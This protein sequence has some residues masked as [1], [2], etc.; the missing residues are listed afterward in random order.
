VAAGSVVNKNVDSES[1]VGGNPA[2]LIRYLN[3]KKTKIL[4]LYSEIVG[5]NIPVF[6]EYVNNYNAEVH[7]VH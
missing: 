6:K 5:Y 4:Y 7:V 2:K 3:D 1:I